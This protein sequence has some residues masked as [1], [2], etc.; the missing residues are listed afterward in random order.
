MPDSR[1]SRAGFYL[2]DEIAWGADRR[3]RL[4]PGVRFEYYGVDTTSDPLYLAASVNRAPMDYSQFAV[5]PKL[6]FL[7]KLDDEHTAYFQYANGFRNPTPE[8]LNGSITNTANNYNT[9]SNPNLKK[10]TSHSFELGLRRQGKKSSWST[11]G[12]YNYYQNFIQPFTL[13]AAGPP[14][15][16]QST[17][18]SSASIWGFEA[19]GET[20]LDFIHESLG[21]FGLFGNAAYIRGNDHQNHQPLA[22][23][24]PFKLVAGLRYRHESFQVELLSTYYARKGQLPAIAGGQFSPPSALTLDLVARWQV[25]KNVMLTAGLYNLTNQKY[26]LYQN[27]R[28]IGPNGV[29]NTSPA[30]P[31]PG[32]LDRFTQPGISTRIALTL[33]F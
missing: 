4:T 16:F 30:T 13:V 14:Q 15:V 33:N 27:V 11:A 18:L 21:N 19:K 8:D 29:S 10:E 20:S 1:T 5:A 32:S 12:F 17:N 2:Q 25:S 24:D 3:Y 26:W 28:N 7:T 22:S 6:A 23:I 31:S 9:I